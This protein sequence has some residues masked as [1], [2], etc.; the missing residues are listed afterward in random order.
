MRQRLSAAGAEAPASAPAA[1]AAEQPAPESA[2]AA[3]VAIDAVALLQTAMDNAAP[4]YHY[5][6]IVT[7]GGSTVVEVDGDRIGEGTRVGVV[8]DGVSVQHVIT[9][10]GTWVQPDGGDW[11]QMDTPPATVDPI[12]ALRSPSAAT[13]AS[14]DGT[15]IHLSVSVPAASLG[16]AGDATI[17]LA[18]VVDA[19]NLAAVVYTT[20]IEAQPARVETVVG[21]VIDGT[22]V[23]API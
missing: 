13:V 4:G 9:P 17:Y 23:V 5:H 6:S 22:P 7:V 18:V 21:P 20:T 16:L 14:A 12:A 19:G 3:T 15:A 2:P 11:D 8:R 1:P 10:G